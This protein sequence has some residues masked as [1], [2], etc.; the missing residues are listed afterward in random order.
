[1]VLAWM[2]RRRQLIIG[3]PMMLAVRLRI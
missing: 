2:E 3:T 1:M